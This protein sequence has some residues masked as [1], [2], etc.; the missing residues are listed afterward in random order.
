M[1]IWGVSKGFLKRVLLGLSVVAAIAGVCCLD[2]YYIEPNYP[3]VI[4]QDIHIEGLPKSL[5]GLKIV[6][7]SDLHIVKFGKREARAVRLVQRI[8]PDLICLTGDYVEDDGITSGDYTTSECIEQAARFVSCLHAEYGVYAVSG[9]WDPP[10]VASAFERCGAKM[11]DRTL[12][13][14]KIRKAR[15]NLAATEAIEA[16]AESESNQLDPRTPTIV[17]DHF[18]EAVNDLAKT[19]SRV[20][21]VLA[22]H[23]HGGQVGWPF[24]MTDV[25]Y[26]AGLYKVGRTQVYVSRGLGMHTYAVRFNCP[27][28]I[29][30]IVLR[31]GDVKSS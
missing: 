20:D 5:D 22:G 7:L 15:L 3:R 31:R 11:I 6:H 19:K 14:L 21:L 12:V 28:E 1:R 17:L 4:R 29:T 10:E 23:W 24:K 8:K 16:A 26:L 18:P 30:L 2:A 9:N 27:A 25:K 13:T